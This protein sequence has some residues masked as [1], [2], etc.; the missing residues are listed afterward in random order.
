MNK[1]E[2]YKVV[3]DSMIDKLQTHGFKIDQKVGMEEIP[4]EIWVLEI[5]N[6]KGTVYLFGDPI[7][8]KD[9]EDFANQARSF[10]VDLVNKSR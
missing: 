8:F 4:E 2:V 3:A 7:N 1:T 10:A 9:G 5:E 6:T